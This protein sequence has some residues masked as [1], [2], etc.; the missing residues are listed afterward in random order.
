MWRATA[1]LHR[2]KG[3]A[4]IYG[5]TGGGSA[6][7]QMVS[8]WPQDWNRTVK[9]NLSL[10]ATSKSGR[11]SGRT[12]LCRRKPPEYMETTTL[13]RNFYLGFLLKG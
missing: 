10:L 11:Y 4:T 12:K 2:D 7:T 9:I 13:P 3:P 6:G 5:G 1:T 8:Y